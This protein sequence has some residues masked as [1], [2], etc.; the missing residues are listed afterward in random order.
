MEAY[1]PENCYNKNTEI[2]ING[3]TIHSISVINVDEANSLDIQSAWNLLF[4]L[5]VSKEQRQ[6]YR[7]AAGSGRVYASYHSL[8]GRGGEDWILV[9]ENLKAFHAGD[10]SW[11]GYANCNMW[12][13]GIG[14]IGHKTSGFTDEQYSTTA[15]KCARLMKEYGFPIE[16]IAGHE[17]ISPD[18]KVDPGIKTGNFDMDRLTR[19]ISLIL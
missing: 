2:K 10:S 15:M 8:I 9:P 13:Y 3:V 18:R 7:G 14:L 17:E 16:N 1:L 4:D 12:M 11:K 5:N 19:E 6:W